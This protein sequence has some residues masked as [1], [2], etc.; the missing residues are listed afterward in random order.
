[1]NFIVIVGRPQLASGA[2]GFDK[3]LQA[4]ANRVA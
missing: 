3:P 1:M 2:G 4:D